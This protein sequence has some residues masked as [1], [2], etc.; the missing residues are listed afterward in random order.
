MQVGS[1][2]NHPMRLATLA[3]YREM[4]YAEGSAPTLVTLRK[5]IKEI[6][7][8]RIELGRYYVDLDVNDRANNLSSGIQSRLD[9]LLNDPLLKAMNREKG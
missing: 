5:R 1:R 7:G 8:G 6:P 2:Y 3:A 4:V 9:E